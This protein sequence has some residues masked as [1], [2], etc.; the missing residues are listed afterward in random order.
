[1]RRTIG[2]RSRAPNSYRPTQ[3]LV[4]RVAVRQAANRFMANTAR[5]KALSSSKDAGYVDLAA[6]SYGCDTTGSITL[7]TVI[8]QGASVNQRVGKRIQLT[9]LQIRGNVV[10]GST[11]T[12]A[13][14]AILVVYDRR[15]TTTTT[16][17]DVLK[18]VASNSMNNDDNTGRF[19]ILRRIDVCMTGNSTTPATGGELKDVTEYIPLKGLPTVYKALGTG[20]IADTE[21]GALY[22]ITVGDKVAGTT[23]ALL[24]A[25]TRLRFQDV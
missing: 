25:T 20:A 1:M 24:Q 13:D 19:K 23:S 2:K 18:T 4:S 10:A 15:P 3:Q 17:L 8:T 6:A 11:G 5:P 22:L 7:L 14:A 16:I 9:S 12:T 21:E